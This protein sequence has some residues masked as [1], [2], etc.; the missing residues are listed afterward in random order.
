MHVNFIKPLHI[1]M[2]KMVLKHNSAVRM[3]NARMSHCHAKLHGSAWPTDGIKRSSSQAAEVIEWIKEWGMK[4]KHS[5]P[6]A[7]NCGATTTENAPA[8][9]ENSWM[10]DV[11]DADVLK[12]SMLAT[13]F[14]WVRGTQDL[15]VTHG[16][17]A[18]FVIQNNEDIKPR[19][20]W[21]SH[22]LILELRQTFKT[23]IRSS[24][25]D[26]E[27]WDGHENLTVE[28]T[29]V[30]EKDIHG[31]QSNMSAEQRAA[32][33]IAHTSNSMLADQMQVETMKALEL[34]NA[35]IKLLQ[36]L[37]QPLVGMVNLGSDN[38]PCWRITPGVKASTRSLL[39]V[40]LMVITIKHCLKTYSDHI[41]ET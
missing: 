8:L 22:P 23:I 36:V 19:Q 5:N 6:D 41:H 15:R 4:E 1:Q 13:A 14:E 31:S 34:D 21:L 32:L 2:L 7:R 17:L 27:F 35:V 28:D 10:A 3:L 16:L 24:I 33:Q 37:Q 12:S 26:W 11:I 40:R 39:Q 30:L 25:P 20:Q 9:K 38:E 29:T 18:G